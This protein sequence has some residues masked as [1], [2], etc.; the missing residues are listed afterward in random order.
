MSNYQGGLKESWQAWLEENNLP[1][2]VPRGGPTQRRS[3]GA[4]VH[5]PKP[6]INVPRR[7]MSRRMKFGLAG[8]ALAAAGGIGAALK[9]RND[10]KESEMIYEDDQGN[11]FVLVHADNAG[12]I[13]ESG[14]LDES[15]LDEMLIEGDD[16]NA[17][18]YLLSLIHI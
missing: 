15:E 4:M 5:Q 8:G 14:N 7:G 6:D 9:G 16:G 10:K 12:A 3:N 13:M 18:I 11:Q 2:H 17:Y 1:V